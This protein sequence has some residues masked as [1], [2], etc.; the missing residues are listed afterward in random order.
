MIAARVAP[1][2]LM[3]GLV[4]ALAGLKVA[5]IPA[6]IAALPIIAGCLQ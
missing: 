3:L 1:I 2:V 5:A 6:G 4:L